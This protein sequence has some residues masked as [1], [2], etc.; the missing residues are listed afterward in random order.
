M[1]KVFILICMFLLMSFIAVAAPVDCVDLGTEQLSKFPGGTETSSL[2]YQAYNSSYYINDCLIQYPIGT[3]VWSEN[4]STS[5]NLSVN[6]FNYDFVVLSGTNEMILNCSSRLITDETSTI[7][8]CYYKT[9]YGADE[10]GSNLVRNT[11][12]LIVGLG[13][14]LLFINILIM[15]TENFNFEKAEG[16]ANVG[17]F[18]GQILMTV[19]GAIIVLSLITTFINAL[20]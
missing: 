7:S 8:E 10:A 5:N 18:I 4:L 2:A 14:I 11:I 15:Q 3:V 1:K 9:V 20:F 17:V 16:N 13:I 12:V 6:T 19:V